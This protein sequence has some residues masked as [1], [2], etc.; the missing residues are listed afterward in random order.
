LELLKNTV[1]RSERIQ[2]T[3]RLTRLV[4]K[5]EVKQVR[6]GTAPAIEAATDG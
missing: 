2:A 1:D 6:Q 5:I 4:R 3:S